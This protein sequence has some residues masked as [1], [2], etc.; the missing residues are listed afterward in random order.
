MRVRY[1]NLCLQLAT[2]LGKPCVGQLLDPGPRIE[3]EN[4]ALREFYGHT[5][6]VSAITERARARHWQRASHTPKSKLQLTFKDRSNR[7]GKAFR[8]ERFDDKPVS[9]E[10]H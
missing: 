1:E 6:R 2:L 10:L 7:F 4:L 5:G 9:P 8:I 3:N